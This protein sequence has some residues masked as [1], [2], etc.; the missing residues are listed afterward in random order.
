[1]EIKTVRDIYLALLIE[2]NKQ[3]AP[4]ILIEDFNLFLPKA[5]QI[6]VNKRVN[7]YPIGQQVKDDLGSLKVLNHP[8]LG[9]TQINN[10]YPRYF[11]VA[12][13]ENYLHL[14]RC[15]QKVQLSHIG[16]NDCNAINYN[17]FPNTTIIESDPLQRI[18]KDY[19][20]KPSIK[21][22]Y[23]TPYQIFEDD[24]V[25]YHLNLYCGE[26]TN[27]TITNVYI[28]YLRKPSL[29]VLRQ[30]DIY[31]ETDNSQKM[32]FT[33]YVNLE[34]LRELT[35]LI[36]ENSSDPRLSTNGPVNQSIAPPFG[37]QNQS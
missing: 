4:S 25:I 5:I 18:L 17:A 9:I 8:V 28:D 13:P 6:Y 16:Q 32:E 35:T 1:M 21:R 20:T 12:L 33:E 22:V 24:K 10:S 23:Y 7:L 27:L 3:E 14:E 11:T 31:S 19:Y 34:I 26:D 30:E 15:S 29:M 36:L 2:L 37:F